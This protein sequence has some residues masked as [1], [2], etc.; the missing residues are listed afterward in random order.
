[1]PLLTEVVVVH[2]ICIC[3]A[4]PASLN[5]GGDG[6][7]HVCFSPSEKLCCINSLLLDLDFLFRLLGGVFG[8]GCRNRV[9]GSLAGRVERDRKYMW[10][11]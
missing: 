3:L 6:V 11:L 8:I 9:S 5:G 1:M 7:L 10:L 2:T 4:R